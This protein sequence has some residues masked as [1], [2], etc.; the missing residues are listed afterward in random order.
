MSPILY[1]IM[2]KDIPDMN[3]GKA[4]A[5]AAHIGSDFTEYMKATSN[6]D[7]VAAFNA[8]K[9]DRTFGVTIS[10]E[11]TKDEIQG[12]LSKYWEDAKFRAVVDPTYPI[13]SWNGY[14]YTEEQ[15]T[16][17]WVFCLNDNALR[18]KLK[19]FPLHP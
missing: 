6:P 15:T 1:V 13:R 16:G 7:C 4:V 17:W 9:E 19:E 11:L 2:R 14:V 12:I 3:P 5:Q 8:W 10:L 18:Q